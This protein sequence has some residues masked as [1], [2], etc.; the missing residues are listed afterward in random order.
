MCCTGTISFLRHPIIRYLL[1]EASHKFDTLAAKTILQLRKQYPQIKLILVLPC[2]S[3]ADRWPPADI[4][5]Y[6]EI[7][8]QADKVVYT[9]QKYTRDCMFKRNRHLVDY[10]SVCICYLNKETGGTAYTVKYAQKCGLQII[11]IAEGFFVA[12]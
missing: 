7:M 5:A 11:N 2:V 12:I 4:A 9:S 1:C 8:E 10:S 3:Q 6:Q